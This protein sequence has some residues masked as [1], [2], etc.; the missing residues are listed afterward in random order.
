[1]L[2][3][4]LLVRRKLLSWFF[5]LFL[6]VLNSLLIIPVVK[7]KTKI[8]LPRAIPIWA[9][10]IVVKEIIDTPLLVADKKVKTLSI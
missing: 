1:M 6:F 8:K 4:L 5:F 9:P 7:E 3:S 10:I 2:L